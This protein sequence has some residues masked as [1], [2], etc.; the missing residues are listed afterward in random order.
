MKAAPTHASARYA[1][2][3]VCGGPANSTST[4]IA[5]EPKAAK[6]DV[7]GCSITLSAN[8]KTAGMTIAARAALLSAALSTD[9]AGLSEQELDALGRQRATQMSNQDG[10]MLSPTPC[11]CGVRAR[12]ATGETSSGPVFGNDPRALRALADRRGTVR[13]SVAHPQARLFPS[14][15]CRAADRQQR[16][17]EHDHGPPRDCERAVVPGKDVPHADSVRLALDVV[18]LPRNTEPFF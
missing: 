14:R 1:T 18:R 8:A 12:A 5:N 2:R 10:A 3:R 17:D 16:D 4:S 9:G 15:S 11:L 7:C 6:S 13:A